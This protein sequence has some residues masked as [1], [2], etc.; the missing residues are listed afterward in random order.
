[1]HIYIS[2]NIKTTGHPLLKL[3]LNFLVN[4]DLSY[5]MH[6]TLIVTL[7]AFVVNIHWAFFPTDNHLST[8]FSNEGQYSQA[9]LYQKEQLK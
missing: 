1:M 2:S 4:L 5:T 3:T 9:I 7:F 6:L 8:E